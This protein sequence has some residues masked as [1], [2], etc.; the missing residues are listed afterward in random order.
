MYIPVVFQVSMV[1]ILLQNVI[2]CEINAEQLTWL[3][4]A[5]SLVKGDVNRLI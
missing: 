5:V 1:L 4:G 2:I 3:Y